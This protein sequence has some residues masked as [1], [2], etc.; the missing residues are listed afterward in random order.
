[1]RLEPA[2]DEARAIGSA[3]NRHRARCCSV[4][5]AATAPA[6]ACSPSTAPRTS[7]LREK[8]RRPARST[9]RRWPRSA[10]TSTRSAGAPRRTSAPARCERTRRRRGNHVSFAPEAKKALELALREAIDLGDR[11]IGDTHVLLGLLR[12]GSSDRL[13]RAV[14]ADPAALR[15]ALTPAG[16]RRGRGA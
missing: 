16:S 2:Q 11:E 8:G 9:A 13:L 7:A 4:S 6:R 12:E 1:M 10:S 15:E 3:Q 14:G 5:R